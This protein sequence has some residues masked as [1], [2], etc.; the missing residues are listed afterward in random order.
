[1]I[2]MLEQILAYLRNWFDVERHYGCFEVKNG[3]IELP[4]VQKGQY[5]RVVGSVFNDGVY[6][7]GESVHEYDEAFRGAVWALAIPNAVIDMAVEVEAWEEKNAEKASGLY[8]SESFGGYSYTLK[9]GGDASVFGWQS[10]FAGKLN[11][12]RKI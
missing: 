11:R 3:G 2:A 6:K 8:Q 10:A 1:M 7:Y 4:F 12:W 5:Y 9:S